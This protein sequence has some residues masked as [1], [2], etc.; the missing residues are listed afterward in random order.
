MVRSKDSLDLAQR[1][2]DGFNCSNVGALRVNRGGAGWLGLLA[3]PQSI[4]PHTRKFSSRCTTLRCCPTDLS[5]LD[6]AQE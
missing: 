1:R 4:L 5:D 3:A 2:N 6:K